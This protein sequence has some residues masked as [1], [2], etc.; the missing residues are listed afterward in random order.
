M[1]AEQYQRRLDGQWL[2]ASGREPRNHP[3]VEEHLTDLSLI[4]I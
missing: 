2:P 1:R 4:H 3:V